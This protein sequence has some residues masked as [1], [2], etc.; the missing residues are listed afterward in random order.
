[1]RTSSLPPSASSGFEILLL[2]TPGSKKTSSS[3]S[4][5]FASFNRLTLC[6]AVGWAQG[7]QL[8]RLLMG[9]WGQRWE[10]VG[11]KGFPEKEALAES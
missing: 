4:S 1:M 2:L 11:Q 8:K 7:I 5:C 9:G 3:F 6:Q 10:S